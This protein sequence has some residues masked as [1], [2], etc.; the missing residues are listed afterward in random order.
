MKY[1]IPSVITAFIITSCGGLEDDSTTDKDNDVV[2][3]DIIGTTEE[4]VELTF[5]SSSISSSPDLSDLEYK[6]D[7]KSSYSWTD[8]NG[9]NILVNSVKFGDGTNDFWDANL[10]SAHYVRT[11]TGLSLIRLVQDYVKECEFDITL[12]FVGIPTITDI[13]GDDIAEVAICYK[14]ACRSDMSECT[15]KVIMHDDRDK[16]ALRGFELIILSRGDEPTSFDYNLNNF[17][18]EEWKNSPQGNMGRYENS[19]E[20]V[21]APDGFFDIADS[22]WRAHAFDV[23]Y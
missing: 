11:D 13:N 16:F 2:H 3:E 18:T 1:F 22:V 20:F 10:Y 7:L 17:T 14:S 5:E 4:V 21:H 19:N 15:M 6:G 8:K 12:K 23:Y 9:I